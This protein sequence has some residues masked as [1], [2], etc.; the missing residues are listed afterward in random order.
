MPCVIGFKKIWSSD[1]FLNQDIFQVTK[2]LIMRFLSNFLHQ[3]LWFYDSYTKYGASLEVPTIL[4]LPCVA[5]VGMVS[6]SMKFLFWWCLVGRYF[7]MRCVQHDLT[8]CKQIPSFKCVLL[9]TIQLLNTKLL[10]R[11][12]D[13]NLKIKPL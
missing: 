3:G 10:I 4:I 9:K 1:T 5:K 6:V 8:V 7:R 12:K 11:I 2:G 13:Q